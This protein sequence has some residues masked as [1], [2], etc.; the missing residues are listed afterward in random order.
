M[1]L[2]D[3]LFMEC[4][5]EVAIR[6]SPVKPSFWGRYVDDSLTVLKKNQIDDFTNHLNSINPAIQFTIEREQDGKLAML[7]TL[8]HR[9]PDGSIKVT[10][11]QKP[12]HTNQYLDFKSHHPLQHKLSVVRTLMHRAETCVTEDADKETEIGNIK[13]SLKICGYQEWVFGV[14]SSGT[15]E[16]AR[17]T[18]RSANAN[19]YKGSVTLPYVQG[20][21]EAAR[22]IFNK[23][24]ISV[25]FKP[26]ITLKSLLVAPK[27]KTPPN[28]CSGTIYQISCT[29]CD[30]SYIG[31]SARPLE[32]RINEH[33]AKNSK[34]P[35][36]E[37][38]KTGHKMDWKNTKILDRESDWFRRGVKEAIYIRTTDCDLNRDQGRHKLSKAYNSILC[39]SLGFSDLGH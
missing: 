36:G 1:D 32:V 33:K 26:Q 24:G 38:T 9:K 25:H 30:S 35:A 16:N 31:E 4:F 8:L 18:R 2:A 37:H 29:D 3:F 22:R 15:D 5:E 7:D 13:Q 21:S 11:Y 19:A 20:V 27:D 6:T 39:R 10:I 14:A 23:R 12:T 17:E 34:S 28:K